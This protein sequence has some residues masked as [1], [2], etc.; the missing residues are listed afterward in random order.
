MFFQFDP[1][2]FSSD[3][4]LIE[5]QLILISYGKVVLKE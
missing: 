3:L 2:I 4:V 1:Q 5:G